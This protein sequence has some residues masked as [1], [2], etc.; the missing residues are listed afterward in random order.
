MESDRELLV[1]VLDELRWDPRV[2]ATDIGAT[3]KDGAVTIDG[4]VDRFTEAL[5]A[6]RAIKRLPGVKS[7]TVRI[8]V[9]PLGDRA[10]SAEDIAWEVEHALNCTGPALHRS[11][12]W[13][14]H[15]IGA[16]SRQLGL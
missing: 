16:C 10:W 7:L 8:E 2:N 3:V 15:L 4:S 1:D 9:K 11:R 12:R 13:V 14:R 6:E 5:A